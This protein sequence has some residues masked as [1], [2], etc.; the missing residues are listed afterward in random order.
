MPSCNI[1]ECSLPDF[2]SIGNRNLPIHMTSMLLTVSSHTCQIFA[3]LNYFLFNYTH[4]F[5]F[6]LY[7][8]VRN[9]RV[10]L[11]PML[12]F[13]S[14]ST[15]CGSYFRNHPLSN[16]YYNHSEFIGSFND[17]TDLTLTVHA[18]YLTLNHFLARFVPTVSP[19]T[20]FPF[21]W[22]FLYL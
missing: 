19:Q 14:H 11:S 9:R 6:I 10:I 20:I 15:L 13:F 7:A 16:F 3:K 5:L 12:F 8:A 2:V 17:D 4:G 22:L 1:Q 18:T 21:V